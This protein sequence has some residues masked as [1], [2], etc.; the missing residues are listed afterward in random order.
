[1]SELP[2]LPPAPRLRRPVRED[3]LTEAIAGGRRRRNRFLAGAGAGALSVVL[4]LAGVLS[5]PAGQTDSLQFA[6]P[7]PS[8]DRQPR[9]NRSAE[10][11]PSR[12]PDN[13]PAGPGAP[14]SAGDPEAG[15]LAQPTASPSDTAPPESTAVPRAGRPKPLDQ[16]PAFREQTDENAAGS[17]FCAPT[18]MFTG[19]CSYGGS[20]NGPVIRRGEVVRATVGGSCS[21]PDNSGE[22]VYAFDGGQETELVVRRAGIAVFRFSDTVR[23]PDGPH[24]RRLRPGRCIEWRQTWRG[25]TTAGKAVPAGTYQVTLTMT[26]DR[27]RYELDGKTY[28]EGRGQTQEHS[29]D[30]TLLD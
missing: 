22:N 15:G 20:D 28:E 21:G 7:T 19:A 27:E 18:K 14:T 2:E 30:V 3:R 24:E 1:M 11:S 26:P 6:E 25:V 12:N 29:F 13:T 17:E 5:F 23:Y 4:L 16:R 8:A 9:D 10:A